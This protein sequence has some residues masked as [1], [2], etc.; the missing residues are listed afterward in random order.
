MD[1]INFQNGNLIT[2]AENK[3]LFI[4]F[5]FEYN[6]FLNSLKNNENYFLTHLPIQLD[7]SCNGFQHLTLLIRDTKLANELNLSE[8]KFSDKPKDFYNFI[9]LKLNNYFLKE[10][11]QNKDLTLELKESYERLVSLEIERDLIKKPLMTKP[12][13]VSARAMIDYLKEGFL[14][15][16]GKYLYNKNKDLF[17]LEKD[18]QNL[19]NNI[20]LVLI[21]DFPN[22]K[23][24]L[25]YFK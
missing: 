4:A 14:K 7:A 20:E 12:Y 17:L 22:L 9:A 24:L 25:V 2:K 3:L 1:I 6:N 23:K 5:C 15:K 18:F 11:T 21:N 13:N 19:R 10:L 16:E 8:S